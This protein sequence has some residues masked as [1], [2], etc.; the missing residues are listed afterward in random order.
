MAEEEREKMRALE[1]ERLRRMEGGRGSPRPLANSGDQDVNI[2]LLVI[3]DA[4]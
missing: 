1:G 2:R 3:L 4:N